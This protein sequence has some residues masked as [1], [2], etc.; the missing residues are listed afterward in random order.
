DPAVDDVLQR[1]MRVVIDAVPRGLGLRGAR[2]LQEADKVLDG[3]YQFAQIGSA[4]TRGAGKLVV[5]HQAQGRNQV[6]SLDASYC[7]DWKI[8]KTEFVGDGKMY[9]MRLIFRLKDGKVALPVCLRL[10]DAEPASPA[11]L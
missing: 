8:L 4:A 7:A 10:E 2:F 6:V 3:N 1:L 9:K 5:D 11:L